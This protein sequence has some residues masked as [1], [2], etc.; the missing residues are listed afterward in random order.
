MHR[1]SPRAKVLKPGSA[2]FN[3]SAVHCMVRNISATG[4]LLE[5]AEA[6][7][8]PTDFVLVLPFEG[9]RKPCHLVWRKNRKIGLRFE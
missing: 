7:R 6:A 1:D 9:V 3:G 2:E 8:I 4:A 5:S